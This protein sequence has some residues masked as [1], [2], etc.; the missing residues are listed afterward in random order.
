MVGVI[1]ILLGAFVQS[2]QYAFEEKVMTMEIPAPPM[3]LIGMEGLWGT[4]LCLFILYPIAYA[5]HG[6][7]PY[8]TYVMIK[9]SVAIQWTFF[10]YFSSIFMY[11]VFGVLVTYTLNSVWHAI[12]DNFRPMTVWGVDLFIFYSIT[13]S[14]GES[15]SYGSY[16]QLIGM[17][18]LLYGTAIYNA[19]NAGSIKLEGGAQSLFMDFTDEYTQI[20]E[21]LELLDL[22]MKSSEISTPYIHNMSPFLASPMIPQAYQ[23][24]NSLRKSYGTAG[25]G[26]NQVTVDNRSSF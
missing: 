26:Y 12:L 4:V 14:F 21:E 17:F 13:R 3:L 25:G 8:N 18:V 24:S 6:E 5:T 15:W 7:D 1:L 2:L 20:E 23:R 19:P 10:L 9:N 11:N 16:I 22:D